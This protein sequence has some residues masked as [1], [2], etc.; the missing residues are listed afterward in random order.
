MSSSRPP[1]QRRISPWLLGGFVLVLLTLLVLLQSSN[2][3]KEFTVD[4]ASDTLLLYALSS[5]NFIA[6]VIFGFIFLRSITKL[7]RE[8]RTL[9]LGSKIKSRLLLY[10]AAVSLLPIIA[11]AG[12][13]YL[14]MNRALER[15]FAQFPESVLLEARDVQTRAAA[16]E[17]KRLKETAAVIASTLDGREISEPQLDAIAAAGNLTWI[18]VLS[19]DNRTLASS[20][21]SLPAERQSE[22]DAM[23]QGVRAGNLN[24]P[25]Y[26]DGR[27]IEGAM[28]TLTDGRR[29]FVVP[30]ERPGSGVIE[31]ADDSLAKFDRLKQRQI[32]VRQIGLLTLGVLTF[33]LIFASS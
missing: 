4:T 2:L 16:E 20:G 24:D 27:G 3:W 14:F 9:Q 30:S 26:A 6:F 21:K 19:K 15:W 33:L 17:G 8:R 18:E 25:S 5:L 11:M 22:L 10:F 7:M 23:L 13:S 31:M 32:M 12:F 1:K 29:L 28:A